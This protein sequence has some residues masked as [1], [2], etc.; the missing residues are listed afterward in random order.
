MLRLDLY[1]YFTLLKFVVKPDS[2]LLEARR[3]QTS[4]EEHNKTSAFPLLFEL[5]VVDQHA[6]KIKRL[7]M[8]KNKDF[9]RE[10]F[11]RLKVLRTQFF[12]GITCFYSS[13]VAVGEIFHHCCE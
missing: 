3:S 8:F 1:R 4:S 9:I 13:K 6:E 7:P 10:A 12:F 2:L 11:P 5:A